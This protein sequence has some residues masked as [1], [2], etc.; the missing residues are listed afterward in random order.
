MLSE[1]QQKAADQFVE[2]LLD[3]DSKVMVLEGHAGT[4]KSYLTNHLL[5]LARAQSAVLSI[6]V[7]DAEELQFAITATTNKAARVISE[8]TGEDAQTIHSFLKLRVQ[9]DYKTGKTKIYPSK[10]Y[11][12]TENTLIIIDEASMIDRNLLRLIE[13]ST[14]K[15]KVLYIGD[16][17]QL[18]PIFESSCPVFEQGFETATLTTIQRQAANNPIIQLADKLRQTVATGKFFDIEP[19]G[20]SII[21][22]DGPQF[23]Q[24]IEN[25]FLNNPEENQYKILSWSNK[26]VRDYNSH[27]R[28]LITNSKAPYPGEILVAN[29]IVKAYGSTEKIIVPNDYTVQIT[30]A[31]RTYYGSLSGYAVQVTDSKIQQPLFIPDD[32]SQVD[33]LLKTY[34]KRKEWQKYFA[35]ME[36]V[37]DLRPVYAS[38]VHKSQGSTYD[39]VFINLSDI[40]RCTNADLVAR[41][42]YV[43]ITRAANKVILYGELPKRY[44]GN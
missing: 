30:S 40:G 41:M 44:R 32:F 36:Q 9:N 1:D 18:T 26:S 13:E 3:E 4:G 20:T 25:A 15:C 28:N 5:D 14:C 34:K 16:P 37:A 35:L 23:Q 7:N 39:T 12:V 42:L 27:I 33:E 10:D 17:Y 19:D 21:H 6:L 24:A 22:M 2:F 8:A 11:E 38:T 31:T 29:S 43:A